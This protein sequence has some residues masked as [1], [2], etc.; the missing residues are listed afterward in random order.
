MKMIYTKL[1]ELKNKPLIKKMIFHFCFRHYFNSQLFFRV[2][3]GLINLHLANTIFLHQFDIC[4][5]IG[6]GAN[7]IKYQIFA[8]VKHKP[9][10][11]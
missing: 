3:K 8:L 4:L 9:S 2:Q 5:Y 10:Q 1:S 11:N 7:T 6:T